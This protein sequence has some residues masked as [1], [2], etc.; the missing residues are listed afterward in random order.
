MNTGEA[1]VLSVVM[2]L[3]FFINH[4]FLYILMFVSTL[5]AISSWQW[6]FTDKVGKKLRML[7]IEKKELE[8]ELLKKQWE[9]AVK[10]ES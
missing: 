1:I 8:I 3:L 2:I 5:L 4:T 6:I 9:E 7:E 10:N